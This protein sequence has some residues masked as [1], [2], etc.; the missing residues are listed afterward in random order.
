MVV[1]T[2]MLSVCVLIGFLL[3]QHVRVSSA[4]T[5]MGDL[6]LRIDPSF[7]SS[8]LSPEVRLWYDRFWAGLRNANQDPNATALAGSSDIYNYGRG[9]NM[10][11]TS[12]LQ[13]L[14]VTGDRALLDEVDRLAQLMRAEL[15]DLSILERGGAGYEADGY[16]NWLYLRSKHEEYYGT[17][18]HEMDD[19]LSH[20]LV[21][22]MAYAFYVNR[23]LDTRYAERAQFWTNY[24]QNHF[25]AKWRNRKGI[26]VDFPFLEK[27]LAHA[28]IQWIRYHYYMARLTGDEAYETE[29]KRMAEIIGEHIREVP[30]PVGVAAMWDHGMPALGRT[31]TLGAQRFNYA[32]YT[33]QAAADLA[34][35]EFSV[36]GKPEFMERMALT[37]AY[38]VMDSESIPSLAGQIDGRGTRRESLDRYAVS[39][40]T[41]LARWDE[42][43]KILAIS[44]KIYTQIESDLE[45][46][47]R[48][49][50]PA[51]IVFSL[52]PPPGNPLPLTSEDSR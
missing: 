29:A 8:Q 16:L 14:R 38:F 40:W 12:I 10:H 1:I 39:P 28:H 23:E 42:S 48:I 11:I 49:Q 34:A 7:N 30:T 13:V 37:L 19:M 2:R 5:A 52:T 31:N 47:V 22:A 27:S 25:E 51:G 17:D 20:S 44:E 35:E 15:R 33:V 24:L 32:R 43:R 18:V 6:S 36:F 3:I 45:E 4:Q 41:M 9:L 26:P 21:A 46:P 50:I